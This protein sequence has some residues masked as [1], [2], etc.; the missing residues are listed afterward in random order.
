MIDEV[1]VWIQFFYDD[2]TVSQGK[3]IPAYYLDEGYEI[4]LERITKEMMKDLNRT[5]GHRLIWGAGNIEF[6][7]ICLCEEPES[8]TLA[9][10][11]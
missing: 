2:G 5:R 11:S 7:P 3:R 9:S 8:E 6:Q 1:K 4:M 10:E